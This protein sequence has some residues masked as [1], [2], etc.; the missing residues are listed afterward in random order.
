MQNNLSYEQCQEV[1][2]K[3]TVNPF[4]NQEDKL[5]VKGSNESTRIENVDMCYSIYRGIGNWLGTPCS[6]Y[7]SYFRVQNTTFWNRNRIQFERTGDKL[8]YC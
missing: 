2:N 3:Y 5:L 7:C 6:Y 8:W 1:Y 4:I